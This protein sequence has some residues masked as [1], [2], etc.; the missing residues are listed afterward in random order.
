M[1]ACINQMNRDVL[2]LLCSTEHNLQVN[3]LSLCSLRS[4]DPDLVNFCLCLSPYFLAQF[5][6]KLGPYYLGISSKIDCAIPKVDH[7]TACNTCTLKTSLQL[8]LHCLGISTTTGE[9]E[10]SA[11]TSYFGLID[12]LTG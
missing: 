9:L 8:M 12:Q 7:L 10:F 6:E 5:L 4:S 1:P 3:N 2:Q 11:C